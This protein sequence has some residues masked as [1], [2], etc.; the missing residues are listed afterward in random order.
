MLDPRSRPGL[1]RPAAEVLDTNTLTLPFAIGDEGPGR[2]APG[3]R[4]LSGLGLS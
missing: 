3:G 1:A 2:P 4:S